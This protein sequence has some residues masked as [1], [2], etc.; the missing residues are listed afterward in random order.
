MDGKFAIQRYWLNTG[1]LEAA[2]ARYGVRRG[3]GAY[4]EVVKVIM[5][6]KADFRRGW[7]HFTRED[8]DRKVLSIVRRKSCMIG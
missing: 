7:S 2:V 4:A 1:T 3:D 6:S 8:I 5:R